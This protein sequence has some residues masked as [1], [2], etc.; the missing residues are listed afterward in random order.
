[1]AGEGRREPSRRAVLA[2]EGS[3]VEIAQVPKATVIAACSVVRSELARQVSCHPGGRHEGGLS[4]WC[5]DSSGRGTQV[6]D[7]SGDGTDR[8]QCVFFI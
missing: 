1:M 5:G 6:G 2:E 4:G 8:A 7:G 3:A